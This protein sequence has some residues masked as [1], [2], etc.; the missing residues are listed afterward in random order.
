LSR[1]SLPGRLRALAADAGVR[2]TASTRAIALVG[3]P[4]SIYFAATRLPPQA[5]GLYFV[6]INVI[7][8]AQLFEIGLGTIVVQFAS[9]EWPRLRWT[10]DG[11]LDG[12]PYA[13]HAVSVLVRAA[14]SW[15]GAAAVALL[16]VAG[17][18][19]VLLYGKAYAGTPGG[20]VLP[21]F[22]FV[23][24]TGLYFL[25]VPLVAVAE[26]C[27]DLISVQR[28][29]SWQAVGLLVALWSGIL[30][31]RPL[32]AAWL[33]AG[34]QLA[35]AAIWLFTRHAGLVR[36]MRGQTGGDPERARLHTQRFR[37][38]QRRGALLWLS[39]WLA[40][41]LLTPIVLRL[42]GGDEAGR[43]GV[44]LAIALAPLSLAMAWLHGRYPRFGALVSEGRTAEFDAL[45]GRATAEA[46]AVFLTGAAVLVGVVVMLPSVLPSVAARVLPV[47]ALLGLFGG[48]LASLLLQAMAGWLRAFRDER[49]AGPIVGGSAATIVLCAVAATVGSVRTVTFA[50]ALAGLGIAVP[51]AAAHYL[52]VRRARL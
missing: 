51:L 52:R 35:V 47:P 30:T 15:Y 37:E 34:A 36:G 45:A 43:L 42:Q 24:L 6:A 41:Q 10:D 9:H 3:A 28:M 38:E 49:I 16:V 32:A 29:R 5:Q 13:R 19:G 17:G 20:F 14:L 2:A 12:D 21:W 4:I 39:L 44:T 40:P 27:G 26:G 50:F 48:A 11:G 25:L 1:P 33:G 7:A 23:A 18:G 46:I 31:A 22:G 8:L